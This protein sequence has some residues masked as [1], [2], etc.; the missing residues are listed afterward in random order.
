[1]WW[2]K[3]IHT[4]LIVL[5]QLVHGSMIGVLQRRF[6]A[7]LQAGMLRQNLPIMVPG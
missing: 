1:M 5:E 6:D 4:I 7:L 2:E 3:A